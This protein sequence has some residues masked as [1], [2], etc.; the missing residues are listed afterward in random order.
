VSQH[1]NGELTIGDSHE[2]DL[3][4]DPF[5]RDSIE[6]LILEYLDTFLGLDQFDIVERWHGV[7]AKHPK[8]SYVVAT[9]LPGVM[10]IT[11]VGGAGMTLSFGLAER[12]LNSLW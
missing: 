8:K 3:A 11:G 7:Y 2:Y 4:P 6:R 12:L 9:P 10:A 1:E 5:L